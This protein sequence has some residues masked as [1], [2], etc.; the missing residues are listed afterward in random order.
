MKAKVTSF[1]VFIR[2][3]R[4]PKSEL[5]P[6]DILKTLIGL[7]FPV[8][9][10]FPSIILPTKEVLSYDFYVEKG[11]FL[12]IIKRKNPYVYAWFMQNDNVLPKPYIVIREEK[13]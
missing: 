2:I 6:D 11:I 10:I 8:Y 5:I 1:P 4:P 9:A 3:M 12:R 7:R 13:L